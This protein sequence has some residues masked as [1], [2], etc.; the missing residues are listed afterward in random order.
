MHYYGDVSRNKSLSKNNDSTAQVDALFSPN[1]QYIDY[2]MWRYLTQNQRLYLLAK[3]QPA[4]V[5]Y[6]A[7]L[8]KGCDGSWLTWFKC[9]C[10]LETCY[11]YKS[12]NAYRGCCG[13]NQSLL[14]L[15]GDST[16]TEFDME[17]IDF[18][19]N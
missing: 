7:P 2:R 18:S 1:K 6:K 3:L 8:K 14:C 9:C 11:L 12:D 19:G 5:R 15:I 10:N 17:Y 16:L 4:N 13:F